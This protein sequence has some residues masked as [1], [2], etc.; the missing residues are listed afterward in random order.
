RTVGENVATSPYTILTGS[1]TTPS[2]NY[3]SPPLVA[4]SP[5]PTTLAPLWATGA[6]QTKVYG[7]D[8]PALAGIGVTLGGLINN[9]AIVTWNG[10]VAIN[11]SA[12]T[13]SATALT[14]TAGENVA[15]SPYA[16]LT[17]SFT[18]PS[19]NYSA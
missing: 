15:T 18:T 4:G 9:P 7:Q 8:D 2:T 6:H 19:T 13:S 16:I 12:L 1:F 14:R 17:G 5:L 11:D 10:N 3:S